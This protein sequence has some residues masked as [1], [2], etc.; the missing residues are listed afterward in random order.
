MWRFQIEYMHASMSW[1][2]YWLLVSKDLKPKQHRDGD[3]GEW[4]K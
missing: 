3:S 4:N 1:P 2:T